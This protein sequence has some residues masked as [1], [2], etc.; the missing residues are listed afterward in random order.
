MDRQLCIRAPLQPC[1]RGIYSTRPLGPV[2]ERL[3]LGEFVNEAE[4]PARGGVRYGA[5]TQSRNDFGGADRGCER[6]QSAGLWRMAG[7]AGQADGAVLWPLRRATAGSAG[8]VEVAAVRA[9]HPRQRH[10]LPRR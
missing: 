10:F 5:L 9:Y 6:R 1:R 8:W 3:P 2:I 7:R 4:Y